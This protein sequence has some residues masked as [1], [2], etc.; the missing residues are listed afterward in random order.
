[1]I[2][3]LSMGP[4]RNRRQIAARDARLLLTQKVIEH[5]ATA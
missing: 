4:Q 1:M 3:N 2:E 5:L